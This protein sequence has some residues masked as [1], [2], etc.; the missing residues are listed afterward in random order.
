MASFKSGL[1]LLAGW[2]ISNDLIGCS[3]LLNNEVLL[4]IMN[5]PCLLNKS[6]S[7]ILLNF[8]IIMKMKAKSWLSMKF[9]VR[10]DHTRVI[11]EYLKSLIS[12]KDKVY[13]CLFKFANLT[14]NLRHER[15]DQKLFVNIRNT[16][17]KIIS[18]FC[19]E[20]MKKMGLKLIV[21]RKKR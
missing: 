7:L 14:N 11:Y 10:F 16:S 1:F 6:K 19:K 21:S 4:I 13:D 12:F 15:I 3:L 8:V 20:E 9:F 18:I 5:S 17:T 2:F